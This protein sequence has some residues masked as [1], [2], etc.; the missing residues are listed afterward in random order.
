MKQ[1]QWLFA[2]LLLV[3]DTGLDK[4]HF[5]WENAFHVSF[6]MDLPP[7]SIHSNRTNSHDHGR[8]EKKQIQQEAKNTHKAPNEIWFVCSVFLLLSSILFI[9]KY[10]F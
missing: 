3:A 5:A 2:I 7:P 10:F 9:T 1:S 4:Y 8:G 6:R